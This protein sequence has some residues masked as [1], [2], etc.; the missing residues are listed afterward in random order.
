[1]NDPSRPLE[2]AR[3]EL[4]AQAVARGLSDSEAYREAG[5]K[6]EEPNK[7]SSEIRANPGI[8]ERVEWL[9]KQGATATVLTIQRK[10]EILFKIAEGGEKDSDRISAIKADNDLAGDGAEAAAQASLPEMFKKIALIRQR[11]KTAT[12]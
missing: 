2:N 8:S 1:M 6:G 12:A 10:R 9:Q 7:R 3:H 4:F 11:T 5:Y